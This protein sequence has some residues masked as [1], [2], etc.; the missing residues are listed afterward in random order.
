M[1]RISAFFPLFLCIAAGAARWLDLINFTDLTTGFP[2]EGSYLIRYIL[3]AVMLLIL[4]FFSL[5]VP[6]VPHAL[7]QGCNFAAFLMIFSGAS[8]AILGG[9]TFRNA[10]FFLYARYEMLNL[11]MG[12]LYLVTALWLI[13]AGL[14]R[15]GRTAREPSGNILLGIAGSVSF[16]LLTFREGLT[17]A[18]N[19]QRIPVVWSALGALT[20]LW[21]SVR[22]IRACY[23]PDT[24]VGR[25]LYL[26][27]YS[28]FL[29]NTCLLLPQEW[30]L[31]LAGNATVTV[32]SLAKAITFG[33]FGLTALC[34]AILTALSEETM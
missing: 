26:S 22:M 30:C 14:S 10:S 5:T 16:L 32:T 28:C 7:T 29:L 15:V 20:A 9:L 21:F 34:F 19:I 17:E 25:G 33:V 12:A 24:E 8:F 18:A 1:K 4:F 3:L 11:L 6:Q 27:G 31:W 13:L 2:A 23:L